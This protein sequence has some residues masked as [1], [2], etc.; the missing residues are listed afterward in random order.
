[1]L[2]FTDSLVRM[3]GLITFLLILLE[4]SSDSDNV[5]NLFVAKQLEI[6]REHVR[7]L[8]R[9]PSDGSKFIR[10]KP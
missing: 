9:R 10:R 6:E 4:V 8:E 5:T 1:M 2:A 3:Q 7:I